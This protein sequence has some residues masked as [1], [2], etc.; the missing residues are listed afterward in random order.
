MN[1]Y[2]IIV[3][4]LFT[5]CISLADDHSTIQNTVKN[6]FG[7]CYNSFQNQI[8][9]CNPFSCNYPDFSDAKTWRAHVIR[10]MVNDKCYVIYYSY[11]GSNIV[12][13]PAHC[14]YGKDDI[15]M[16]SKL[17]YNLFTTDS[18]IDMADIKDKI[19]QLNSSLCQVVAKK[20]EP[21]K[22]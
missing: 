13:E 2:L 14:F 5:S 16:I 6:E 15:E 1:K 8:A 19:E 12:G 20:N 3:T 17:Y 4:F 9:A 10:G 18:A 7:S 21:A 11:L 22:K